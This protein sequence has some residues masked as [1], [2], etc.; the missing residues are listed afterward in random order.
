MI[1]LRVNRVMVSVLIW[2]AP[3]WRFTSSRAADMTAPASAT[4]L[5]DSFRHSGFRE[6]ARRRQDGVLAERRR[7][8]RRTADS[9]PYSAVVVTSSWAMSDCSW[10][11]VAPYSALP[12]PPKQ[13]RAVVDGDLLA[14][15]VAVGDLVVV[16]DSAA[17]PRR[18]RDG[19]RRRIRRAACRDGG[20]VRVQRPSAVE[21]GDGDRRGVGD[22][23]IADG[24]GHQRAMLDGAAHGGLQRCG[25]AAAQPQLPPELAQ[26]PP[27]R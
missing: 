3:V 16:Q 6:P 24:D 12:N 27:L 9:A 14:A 15:Q 13:H 1:W 2:S 4:D 20:S 21:R 7:S 11:S 10:A 19:R 22:A 5:P 26:R 8:P 17:I 18:R 23:E 25:F